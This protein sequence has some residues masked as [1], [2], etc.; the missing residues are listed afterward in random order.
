MYRRLNAA[1]YS[2][3]PEERRGPEV[4]RFCKGCA[5]VYPLHA[6]R[7]AGKAMFGRDHNVSPCAYEGRVFAP[8]AAFWEPAVEVLDAPPQT[9]A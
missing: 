3:L 6:A 5:S 9:A 4:G 2:A 1:P 7:H 8:D